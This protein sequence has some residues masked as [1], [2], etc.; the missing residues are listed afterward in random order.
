MI[1]HRAW[2]GEDASLTETE[3]HYVFS[4]PDGYQVIELVDRDRF[5]GI[6][7]SVVHDLM[8]QAYQQGYT[9]GSG[10]GYANGFHDRAQQATAP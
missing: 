6:L 7:S 9:K 3:S 4:W 10:D 1:V 5:Y 2:M 8:V